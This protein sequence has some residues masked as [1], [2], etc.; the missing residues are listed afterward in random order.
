MRHAI[1][2]ASQAAHLA[3]ASFQL[4]AAVCE[5]LHHERDHVDVGDHAQQLKVESTQ[6]HRD[7]EVMKRCDFDE[8]I[9]GFCNQALNDGVAPEQWRISNIIPVPKKGDPTDTNNY[10]GISLTS[11]VTKTLNRMILNRIQPEVDKKFRDNQNGFRKGRSTTSHIL[12]LRRILEGA[13]A[14]NLSAVMVFIDFRKAFDSVDRDTLKKILLAYGIPKKIVDLIFLLYTNTTAQVI[15]PDGKT[16]FFEIQ[17]GVLQG[18]TLAPYLFIIVMDYCMRIALDKHPDLGFTLTPARSR[19]VKAKKIS[20]TD[21]AD[22]IALVTN[23]VKEAEELMRE[24]EAVSACVGLRMNEQKTKYLVE[25]IHEPEEITNIGGQKV[26]LVND[27]LYLGAKIRNSEEDITTRKKKAWIA[28][29]SLKAV[30]KSDL[31]R[32]LKIRLFTATVESVLLY[33][34]ETWTMT[35]RLTKTIDGCYTRMLRM[36]LNINQYMMWITN[37]ELYGNL[38]KVSSKVA[39][40]RLRLAGHAQRHPE[41][42]LHSVLLWEPL[43]GRA[44]RGRPRQTYIDTLRADTGL[45]D[46]RDIANI[47]EHRERWRDIIHGSREHHPT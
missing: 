38:P 42:T 26:E 1:A 24:V 9:L 40:R 31:R 34:S 7:E 30:W 27:F 10:R 39:Q 18:D 8:I 25:N 47:M 36:A 35:K 5:E 44:G 19:R 11:I 14:K 4:E 45:Q 29:H 6:P 41:L 23:T 21:F 32:D 13:R 16:E 22:D 33:G 43:H 20:D 2:E 17:A 46:T 15:T 28:C 12:T 3:I 37:S